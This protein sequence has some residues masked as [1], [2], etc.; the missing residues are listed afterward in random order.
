MDKTALKK[1][2]IMARNA[3]IRS[4]ADRCG[5]IGIRE[6]GIQNPL[7]NSTKDI[8]FFDAGT[9]A[10]SSVSGNEIEKRN[11]L[12]RAIREKERD[13]DYKTAYQYIVE[14]VAYTWFNRLIAIRFME[15]NEYLPSRIRVLSSEQEG[16]LEPDI[17]SMPF[18]ADFDFTEQ[19]RDTIIQLK[20]RGQKEDMDEL[21]RM[22]FVK[23]CDALHENLPELF[24]KVDGSDYTELL[25]NISFTDREGVVYHLVNDIPEESFDVSKEGQVEI[26][27]W[28]YQYYNTEPKDEVFALLKKNVK[29]TKERIPAA[30]QLFTP[31]WIVRYMIEN[32]LGRLWVEHNCANS[33]GDDDEIPGDLN[34]ALISNWKYYL[35][36]APQEPEVEAQLK[37]I[38]KSYKDLTPEEIKVIDPCMGSGHILVYAFDVLMQIYESQGYTQRDAA[39]LIVEKNLYGLDI[40]E[41]AYQLA[42]FAVMMKAR[43]YNRR[44]L[45]GEV[46]PNLYAIEESNGINHNHLK[47]LGAGMSELERNSARTQLESVLDSLTDAKEYGS[48][49]NV[50]PVDWELL[51][52]Y[53]GASEADPQMNLETVGLEKTQAQLK[54]ILKQAQAMAQKYDVVCTNPPY[55]GL[56]SMSPSLFSYVMKHYP[57]TK[58]DL[59]GVF[60][61][62]SLEHY[63]KTAGYI[64]MI[65]QHIWMFTSGFEKYRHILFAQHTITSLVHLGTRAFE[66]ISGE[67]VQTCAFVVNRKH[68]DN[69]EATFVRLVSAQTAAQKEIQYL[70]QQNRFFQ[71][72]KVFSGIPGNPVC[73]WLTPR[74]FNAY[75]NNPLVGDVSTT[76]QGLKTSDDKRFVRFFFEVDQTKIAHNITSISDAA[77]CGKK[78]FWLNKGGQDKWY[79]NN[80]YLINWENDG[81]E[82]KEYAT[83]VAGSFSKNITAIDAYFKECISWP[84]ISISHPSF[85]YIPSGYIFASAGPSLF[86]NNPEQKWYFLGLLN[87]CVTQEL[88]DAINPTINFGVS[89]ILKLPFIYSA[90]Y[91]AIVTEKAKECVELAK[92]DWDSFELSWEFHRHPLLPQ[93]PLESKCAFMPSDGKL[94]NLPVASMYLADEYKR[95]QGEC[96]NRFKHL[97]ANEEELNRIFIDIY[98]LQNELA[99]EVEDKNVAVRKAELG[100]DIRSFI[101][102]AVGCMFGRYS[103]DVD[104]LAYAGGKWD[105]G[106]YKSFLPD[107]DNCI[108]ITDEEYFKDDIIGRLVEFVRTVYGSDTLE[109]NLDFIANALGNKGNTSREV[110][111]NYFLNDFIKD[112]NKTYQ[113]RPIYWLYDSGK[114]NGFKALIYMHRYSED[115]T[116]RIRADY[117]FK[118]QRAYENELKRIQDIIDGS[119]NSREVAQAEKRKEKLTKQLKETRDYDQKLA[120]LALARI[121]IELDDGV[122]A[123]YEKVQA[124]KDGKIIQVLARI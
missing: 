87:S 97:K 69:Y 102:Y 30:T 90:E 108:P 36:E 46:K 111:R 64:G 84:Q 115:T 71:N 32:S 72:T 124:G 39:S 3:L 103:L 75:K 107:E 14:Q 76:R 60:L 19:E 50:E 12:V 25:L 9:G 61:Q 79:G 53:A 106:K 122:K 27:G 95:W 5:L 31:D 94:G 59:Y 6:D 120:H 45:N 82:V 13:S 112:H 89:D 83:Q 38:R 17:L 123:N 91:H 65:T 121:P 114:Q 116:G 4:V 117:L 1:F 11:A 24:Q 101:S 18:D 118:M 104:G 73:Y 93:R 100:R 68:V 88:L 26:I 16:K 15:V 49:L 81:Y 47:Y 92:D 70:N 23:Q 43:Q 77:E 21:F 54:R 37:E 22:L 63:T 51:E 10:P 7:P 55:M 110:I 80:I 119:T 74:V 62:N 34:E 98:G 105:T 113:K 58:N 35:A 48:I 96:D 2:S 85:R 33:R 99:P 57:L 52:R 40:D 86:T 109:E 20:D 66:E 56:K 29:I 67:V 44:I 8:Q 28:M 42:Y 41:R 78:W